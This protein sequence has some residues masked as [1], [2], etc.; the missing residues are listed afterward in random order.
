MDF[1][2]NYKQEDAAEL[3]REHGAKRGS[4]LNN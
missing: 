3:L 4:D 2:I 1:A